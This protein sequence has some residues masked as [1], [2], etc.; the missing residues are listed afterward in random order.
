MAEPDETRTMHC[1]C[2]SESYR[3]KASADLTERW[4]EC[5]E[6]GRPTGL[7]DDGLQ[8]QREWYQKR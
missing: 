4:A 6:C 5:A 7:F 8:K 3:I 2:G 1:E